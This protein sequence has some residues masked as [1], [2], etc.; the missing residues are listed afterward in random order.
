MRDLPYPTYRDQLLTCKECGTRW[1]WTVTEQRRL[2]EE[3]K[4]TD[5]PE[6][7]PVCQ[8]LIPSPGYQRGIVK[9][10]SIQKGYGFIT[11][12][13]GDEIFFH[14]TGINPDS[15]VPDEGDLVEFKI[16]K[17]YRGPQAASVTVLERAETLPAK[18]LHLSK[19]EEK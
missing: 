6:Y 19:A 13:S 7:C 18:L 4:L 17:T 9:W 5:P 11:M 14:R 3:G 12:P 2:A 16:E 10:Y 15:P 8:R 1:I